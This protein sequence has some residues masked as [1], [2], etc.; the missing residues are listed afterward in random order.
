MPVQGPLHGFHLPDANDD[1]QKALAWAPKSKR[2]ALVVAAIFVFLV[3]SL[4]LS[5]LL[6]GA[7]QAIRAQSSI[8]GPLIGLAPLMLIG[9]AAAIWLDRKLFLASRPA[10]ALPGEPYDERQQGLVAMATQRGFKLALALM[11]IVAGVGASPLPAA[12][13][14]G[15][16]L[17]AFTL[18]MSGPQLVL[19]WVLDASDYDVTGAADGDAFDG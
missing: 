18:A 8:T 4:V 5:L 9:A 13:V 16:G 7:I 11:L 12:Y 3:L 1:P 10:F 17:G 15:L 2:R 19:A 14:I 6:D